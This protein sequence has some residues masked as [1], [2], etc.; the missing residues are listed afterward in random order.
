MMAGE[1]QSAAVQSRDPRSDRSLA[2]MQASKEDAMLGTVG[3]HVLPVDS[4]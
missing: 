4:G 2:A 3:N 1:E